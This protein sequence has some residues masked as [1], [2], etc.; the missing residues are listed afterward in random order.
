MPSTQP[1]PITLY[2]YSCALFSLLM[3]NTLNLLMFS[4]SALDMDIVALCKWTFNSKLVSLVATWKL[5]I[6]RY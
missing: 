2:L 4:N 6:E 5:T 3:G 1:L